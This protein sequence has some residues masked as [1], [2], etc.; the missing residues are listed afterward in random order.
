MEKESILMGLTGMFT[1]IIQVIRRTQGAKGTRRAQELFNEHVTSQFNNRGGKGIQ[2]TFLH[3]ILE[4][5]LK[6]HV[7]AND[8]H[9]C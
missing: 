8:L 7:S 1:P 9:S 4:V 2:A 6:C 3:C 5:L